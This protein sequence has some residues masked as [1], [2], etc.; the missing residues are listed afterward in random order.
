MGQVDRSSFKRSKRSNRSSK[1]GY[2]QD[3]AFKGFKVQRLTL[4]GR[5]SALTAL[6]GRGTKRF[7]LGGFN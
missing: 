6:G 3:R 5:P 7:G 4:P 1:T 2:N